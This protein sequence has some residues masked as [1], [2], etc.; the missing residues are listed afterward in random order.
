VTDAWPELGTKGWL[1]TAT[2]L[3]MWS[4][5]VGKT[6]LALEPMLNHWWQV[7][8]YVTPRGLAT[9]VLYDHERAF[10]VEFDFT[11]HALRIRD[12]DGRT[13]S[14][15]LE[16]MT[17]SEF[18]RRYRQ[19]LASI[20][21]KLRIWPKPVEIVESIRFD[22]D[23]VHHS[24]DPAWARAF[25]RALHSVDSVLK[26]FRGR[27]RGK[28][29]P[30]HFF[31]GGFDMAV[32]RFSGRTAPTHPGGIPNCADWVM[33]EAY[34]H[35]VSSAGFWVGNADAPEAAF[36]SYAYPEPEGFSGAQVRPETARYDTTL[37]EFLLPYEAVR[38]SEN[39]RSDVLAFLQSTYEVAATL[40]NWDRRAL[41][42]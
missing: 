8:L 34:S 17:V 33:Q 28:A 13:P 10:D 7:T 31:W 23:V 42:R 39:P 12:S 41:E 5:I 26:E 38:R 15:A 29:S 4:Q 30:V 9:P 3:H 2:T 35:E 19:A 11:G 24:Y 27:F 40:G 25:A 1:Q 32:T 36:Y 22:E 14:F 37:R 20:G 6:R 21:V 16:P 18:H